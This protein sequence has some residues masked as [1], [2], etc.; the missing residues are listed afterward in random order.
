MK[1]MAWLG[2]VSG[3]LVVAA[4]TIAV[5][6][7]Q[8]AAGGDVTKLFADESWYKNRAGEETVFTGKLEGVKGAGMAT[9]LMRSAFY[10]LGDRTIYTGAKTVQALD[11]LVG[12]TVEI[13]GKA[14]DMELEGRSVREIWPASV[15]PLK[16]AP[17][18]GQPA[19]GGAM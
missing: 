17:S 9:T 11:E 15:K 1:M 8:A 5:G 13:R 6:A 7:E 2:V 14:V 10:K 18:A 19:N 16:S 4:V 12:Q 3:L